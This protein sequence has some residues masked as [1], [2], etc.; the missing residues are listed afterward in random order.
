MIFPAWAARL[1]PAPTLGHQRPDVWAICRREKRQA[2]MY[3]AARRKHGN[4]PT[5]C[6]QTGRLPTCSPRFTELRDRSAYA[7]YCFLCESHARV[8]RVPVCPGRRRQ[9]WPA[10]QPKETAALRLAALLAAIPDASLRNGDRTEIANCLIALLRRGS[11]AQAKSRM[12]PI[13]NA[14]RTRKLPR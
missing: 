9:Q 13:N 1:W 10:A 5:L 4:F 8:G 6:T 14:D 12:G 11:S 3:V 2:P 7:P